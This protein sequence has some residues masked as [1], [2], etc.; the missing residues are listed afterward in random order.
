MIGAGL[1][2]GRETL[3]AWLR[4]RVD[5]GRGGDYFADATRH[6]GVAEQHREGV[7]EAGRRAYFSREVPALRPLPGSRLLLRSLRQRYRM[8]LV[9]AGHPG[10]QRCKVDRL[11]LTNA[12]DAI[13]LVD[14]IRGEEKIRAFR[15]IVHREALDPS[16]C[17]AVG[18]RVTGEIRDANRLGMWTV[19]VRRGEFRAME[20]DG[21]DEEPDFT[22][23]ELADLAELLELEPE[24]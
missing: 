24:R 15:Q 18:D 23:L 12:F 5:E 4:A 11:G 22:I 19:R 7:A 8:Y 2:A 21:P 16:T 9:S 1:S 17:L 13:R 14:S 20:P 3:L 6:F 10:T